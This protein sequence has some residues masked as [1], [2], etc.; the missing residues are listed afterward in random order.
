MNNEAFVLMKLKRE[1]RWGTM[2]R[3][4]PGKRAWIANAQRLHDTRKEMERR[5]PNILSVI[6]FIQS[7]MM[8][9]N[10]WITHLD[11]FQCII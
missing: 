8:S 5:S 4:G 6:V 3:K 9:L 11:R 10:E 2:G 1:D 7:H